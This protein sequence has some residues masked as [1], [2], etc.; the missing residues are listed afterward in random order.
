MYRYYLKLALRN[1]WYQKKYTL[2]NCIGLIIACVSIL[3]ISFW[4]KNE[5]SFDRF[6]SK[7][8]RIYRLTVSEDWPNGYKA[9]YAWMF[10]HDWNKQIEPFFPEIEKIARIAPMRKTAVMYYENKFFTKNVFVADSSFF[11]VFDIVFTQGVKTSFVN[12]INSVV[13]SQTIADKLFHDKTAIGSMIKLSGEFEEKMHDYQIVGV[14][15]PLPQNSHFHADF[16]VNNSDKGFLNTSYFYILLKK[17][18]DFKSIVRKFYNF[19]KIHLK[20]EEA[21]YI[22]LHLQPITD[23]H[24]FSNKARELE[25]NGDVKTVWLF[26]LIGIGIL[27][28]A[29]LNYINLNIASYLKRADN[30]TITRHFGAQ[31]IDIIFQFLV[32]SIISGC[33]VLFISLFLYRP[34]EDLLQNIESFKMYPH[35]STSFISLISLFLFVILILAGTY[36]ALFFN[37]SVQRSLSN[38]KTGKSYLPKRLYFSKMMLIVQFSLSVLLIIGSITIKKQNKLALSNRVTQDGSD[39]II[40]KNLNWEVKPL[41]Q[42]FKEELLRNSAITDV[43][44]S[45]TEPSFDDDDVFNI[46]DGDIEPEKKK[47]AL[48][49]LVCDDNL[50]DFLNLKIIAGES[51]PKYIPRQTFESYILNEKATKYLGFNSPDEAI[52]KRLSFKFD[53]DSILFGGKIVGVVKD[54]H[55][56]TLHKDVKPLVMFQQPIWYWTFMVKINPNN[57]VKALQLINASWKKVYPDYP[58]DYIYLD[59]LYNEAYSKELTQSRIINLFSII[60]LLIACLG[61]ICLTSYIA[62]TRTKELGIRRVNGARVTDLLVMLNKNLAKWVVIAIVIAFPVAWYAMNKWLQNF[63]YKIGLSWWIFVLAGSIVLGIALLTISL[64]SW[65]AATTNPVEALRYE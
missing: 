19:K 46:K 38:L 13:I 63:A 12:T 27:V 29:I 60:G 48:H 64:Q 31:K 35:E 53:I 33:F 15:Q 49:M 42:K 41:Y 22:T 54:F 50:I 7:A 8:D 23:I 39:I 61:L 62:E 17:G 1:L 11:D 34:V 59:D 21:Q 44:A 4:I 37:S 55:Y 25:M 5:L 14:M 3:I 52:G 36:P 2:F 28:I 43:S 51:F 24:L 6:R 56:A 45:M 20:Q 10:L 26:V 58:F 9:H 65:R 18:S 30:F 47:L 16:L 32:E 40:F 57:K